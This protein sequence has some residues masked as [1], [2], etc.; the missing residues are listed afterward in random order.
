[1]LE[2]FYSL[3]LKLLYFINHTLS[4][5][6][7]DALMPLLRGKLTWIPLYLI[8]IYFIIKKYGLKSVWVIGCALLTVLIADRISAGLIKPYFERLRPCNNPEIQ[9]WLNLPNGRGSSWSFVSSHAT[10]HFALAV[11]FIMIFIRHRGKYKII[12]PFLSWAFLIAFAQVYIGFHYPSDV[13]AG[14]I[15]GS[16][17]GYGVGKL[18]CLI[19]CYRSGKKV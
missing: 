9:S 16:L 6:V 17:I 18:N 14:G 5:P 2:F 12:I 1:M 8:I 4:N 15:L 10:N 13:I 7:F 19:L 3:D 11:Y